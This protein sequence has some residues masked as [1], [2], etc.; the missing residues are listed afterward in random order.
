MCL[1]IIPDVSTCY[2]FVNTTPSLTT[3]RPGIKKPPGLIGG[4]VA[5]RGILLLLA[6]V[7][8]L[9]SVRVRRTFLINRR[10]GLQFATFRRCGI[11]F[12]MF[13]Y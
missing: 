7:F 9:R 8:D 3:P 10:G 6:G 1:G 4:Q 13:T 2:I 5:G 11:L 12:H